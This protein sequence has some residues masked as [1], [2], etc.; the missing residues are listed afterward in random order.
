MK[1]SGL[2]TND[3]WVFGRGLASYKKDADAIGQNVK[4]R[5]KAFT[6]DWFLDTDNGINWFELLGTRD[7][8]AKI[9]RA[10][11]KSV[12]QTE[13]VI[14]IKSL[15]ITNINNRDLTFQIMYINVFN[16]LIEETLDLML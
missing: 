13:G 14:A 6:D 12:L 11:E 3:D 5:L 7:N 16:V 9:R 2:D 10:I 15:E 4:T 8:E 1:V